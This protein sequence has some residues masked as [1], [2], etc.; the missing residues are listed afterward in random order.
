MWIKDLRTGDDSVGIV[1]DATLESV[2]T[3]MEKRRIKRVPVV[4]GGDVVGIVSRANLLHGLA[5]LAGEAAPASASDQAIR[6]RLYAELARQK[7]APVGALEVIV[8]DGAV[9]LWGAITDERE[10]Q[11]MIVAAE[12]IPGVKRVNDHV[13]WIDTTS[14]MLFPPPGEAGELPK[15]S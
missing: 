12:N 13:S 1:E 2:V 9:D 11:A 14:G 7:W 8:R 6:D 15:A 5:S 4:R 3:L 10:R